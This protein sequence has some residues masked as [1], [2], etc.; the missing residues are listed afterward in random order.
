MPRFAKKGRRDDEEDLMR[1]E[2]RGREGLKGFLGPKAIW[3]PFWLK[4]GVVAFQGLRT[5]ETLSSRVQ[6]E[7]A[8]VVS[9]RVVKRRLR[10]FI[11]S[12]WG[13]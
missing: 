8:R 5:K 11:L 3:K 10:S 1:M 7:V 13:W 9:E 12:F 2:S 4:A 6:R